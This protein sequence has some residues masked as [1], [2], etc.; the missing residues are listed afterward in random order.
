ML[1]QAGAEVDAADTDG[2]T[3]LWKAASHGHADILTVLL[4]AG[5]NV[6]ASIT[7]GNTKITA[8]GFAKARGQ[9]E[10]IKILKAHGAR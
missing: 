10:I 2:A 4:E 9:T 3:P 5:A 1:L 7:L 6:N 8:L